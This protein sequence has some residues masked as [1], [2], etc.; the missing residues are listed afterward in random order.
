MRE[1]TYIG[2][3]RDL[4]LLA[5]RD[6][7]YSPS[8]YDRFASEIACTRPF[9][10]P[11]KIVQGSLPFGL[12]VMLCAETSTVLKSSKRHHD[13]SDGIIYGISWCTGQLHYQHLET[14]LKHRPRK[15]QG[16]I[17]AIDS[18]HT[19]LESPNKSQSPKTGHRLLGNWS[20]TATKIQY[21]Y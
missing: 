17:K 3:G 14:G 2:N 19:S 13:S 18:S 11:R 9:I 1:I 16:R 10:D 6:A 20:L 21:D 12:G 5:Y 8:S 4:Q 15:A 7:T